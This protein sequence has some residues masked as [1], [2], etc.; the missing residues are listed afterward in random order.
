MDIEYFRYIKRGMK[1]LENDALGGS[2][3]RGYG[4]IKFRDLKDENSHPIDLEEIDLAD[5]E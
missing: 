5:V 3:S 1:L 2:G 4:R